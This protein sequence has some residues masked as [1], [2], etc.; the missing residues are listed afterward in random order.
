MDPWKLLQWPASLANQAKLQAHERPRL[1]TERV[2]E[3]PKVVLWPVHR[4]RAFVYMTAIL[5][6]PYYRVCGSLEQIMA[7]TKKALSITLE[8][9]SNLKQAPIQY[10]ITTSNNQKSPLSLG[11]SQGFLNCSFPI[12]TPL[13]YQLIHAIWQSV[14]FPSRQ[15]FLNEGISVQN[16]VFCCVFLWTTRSPGSPSL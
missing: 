4:K 15:I 8:Q 9:P 5:C 10:T 11:R 1:K 2:H 7:N 16:F 3:E 13:P 6:L 14:S 12:T